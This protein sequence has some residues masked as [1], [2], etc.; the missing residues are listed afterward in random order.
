MPPRVRSGFLLAALVLHT[1]AD[2]AT[3]G[4]CAVKTPSYNKAQGSEAFATCQV[5]P[6]HVWSRNPS[7]SFCTFCIPGTCSDGY[8]YSLLLFDDPTL[9]ARMC[10]LRALC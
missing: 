1:L 6:L 8:Y 5:C 2:V 4:K 7:A 10:S 3:L 9:A